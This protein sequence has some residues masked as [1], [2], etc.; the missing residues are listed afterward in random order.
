[1]VHIGLPPGYNGVTV[2]VRAKEPST[3]IAHV[4]STYKFHSDLNELKR[5]VLTDSSVRYSVPDADVDSTDPIAQKTFVLH[6]LNST[7]TASCPLL[8][9][10]L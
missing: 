7:S 9:G 6:P 4:L 1:M 8:T 3:I 5:E 10:T 2:F